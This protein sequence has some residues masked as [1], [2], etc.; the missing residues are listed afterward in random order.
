MSHIACLP[1]SELAHDG[2][3][4]GFLPD[5]AGRGMAVFVLGALPGQTVSCEVIRAK[6]NYLEAV[7]VNILEEDGSL[8]QPLC[9]HASACGGCPLQRMSYERQL[10]WKEK[11]ARAAFLRLG[12]LTEESLAEI[13]SKPEP[14]P[15]LSGYRNKITLAFGEDQHGKKALGFRARKSHCI[16]DLRSCILMEP[17]ALAIVEAARL[18]TRTR[19]PFPAGYLRFLILRRMRSLSDPV[20]RWHALMLTSAGSRAQKKLVRDFGMEMLAANTGLAG[21]IH[22]ERSTP[23]RVARGEKRI[24]AIGKQADGLAMELGG[25]V[26]GLDATSFFQVNGSAANLLVRQV[27]AL[28]HQD[29]PLLDIYS[30]VGA[31]GQLLAANHESCLGLELDPAAVR[32]A[33]SNARRAG[34]VNWRYEAG[35][36]TKKLDKLRLSRKTGIWPTVL[37]DPPRDGL[38]AQATWGLLQLAPGQII[39]VSCNATTMARDARALAPHYRIAALRSVDMFPHTQQLECVGLFERL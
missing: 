15:L 2:R 23:D 8:V 16:T 32:H 28:D 25:R 30:G 3:G 13:W 24:F 4:I 5:A 18:L 22:E 39:Y 33:N 6:N 19:F 35:D 37:V 9:A 34:L 7:A 36:A 20:M 17:E 12:A 14:S 26:F 21:F 11:L 38:T 27:A 1:V 29:G 10:F 31:P